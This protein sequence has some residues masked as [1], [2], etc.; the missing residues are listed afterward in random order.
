MT[1]TAL[2]FQE[3]VSSWVT[4]SAADT[5]PHQADVGGDNDDLQTRLFELAN[6]PAVT[7]RCQGGQRITVRQDRE[8]QVHTGGIVWETAFLLALFL[9]Q[10]QR[11]AT[12]SSVRARH[13]LEVGAGCGLLGMVL[14]AAGCDV[15]LSEHPI[16]L[17]NLQCNVAACNRLS[18]RT[19]VVQLDWTEKADVNALVAAQR[20]RGCPPCFDTIVGTDVVFSEQ[21]V[22]PLLQ[23]IHALA[24]AETTVWLCLQERCAAAH[25]LLL[26]SIPNYFRECTVIQS[27]A[28]AAGED[29]A[30]KVAAVIEALHG[31]L[32]CVLLK[33]TD[34]L[35][36]NAET[37]AS[38]ERCSEQRVP[39]ARRPGTPNT[40]H[41][42]QETTQSQQS[43][44][45]MA[46]CA[47][48]H[49][50]KRDRQMDQTSA[51]GDRA[52]R[53]KR[54]KSSKKNKG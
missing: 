50:C 43:A 21:L 35:Q 47:G 19:R 13:V 51:S 5:A 45:V 8:A 12:P 36:D 38:H 25:K 46:R 49:R 7:Y 2:D 23:T 14:A 29:S 31:Q 26:A 54:K 52:V 30:V 27:P 4:R 32:E 1:E 3:F 17:A 28:A 20:A 16:A 41:R 34:R 48:K 6:A 11:A 40:K 9:E 44:S 15:V 10:Q 18:E 42:A 39:A 22:V 33:L 53:K 37:V 24:G